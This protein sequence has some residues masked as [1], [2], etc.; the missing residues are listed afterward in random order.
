M[1]IQHGSECL[2]GWSKRHYWSQ[3][4]IAHHFDPGIN[5]A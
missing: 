4:G 1:P 2:A 5:Q 3:L